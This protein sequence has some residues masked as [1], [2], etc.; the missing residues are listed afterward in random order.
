MAKNI[1][2]QSKEG[3]MAK[4]P[5]YFAKTE[6]EQKKSGNEIKCSSCGGFASIA[7]GYHE[8][9]NQYTIKE[10]TNK[11]LRYCGDCFYDL[12]AKDHAVYTKNRPTKDIEDYNG[13]EV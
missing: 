7:P 9:K 5:M 10:L 3:L 2:R 13:R 12:V 4:A 1:T 8:P 6:P 11:S